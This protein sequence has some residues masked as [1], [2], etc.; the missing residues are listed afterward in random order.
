MYDQLERILSSKTFNRA[1]RL[2]DFFRYVVSILLAGRAEEIK[3]YNVAVEVFRRNDS[4]DPRIDPIVRVEAARLRSRLKAYLENEGKHDHLV[5]DLPKGGYVPII[6]RSN[7]HQT[8][9]HHSL[10]RQ[11][12]VGM[13]LEGS[14]RLIDGRLCVNAHLVDVNSDFNRSVG[15]DRQ[16]KDI[17]PARQEA[18]RRIV[19]DLRSQLPYENDNNVKNHDLTPSNGGGQNFTARGIETRFESD[20]KV[21]EESRRDFWLAV[22][23]YQDYGRALAILA[24]SYIRLGFQAGM[25]PDWV[26]PR[27]RV[28]AG[29]ALKLNCKLASAHTSL[30]INCLFYDW[31][32]V[33]AYHEFSKAL[34]INPSDLDGLNWYAH[35]VLLMKGPDSALPYIRRALDIRPGSVSTRLNL[36]IVLYFQQQYMES[37]KQIREVIRLDPQWPW[38]HWMAAVLYAQ[39]LLGKEA[40]CALETAMDLSLNNPGLLC[41]LAHI[42]GLFGMKVK[43]NR[44]VQEL[45][46]LSQRRYIPPVGLA[47]AY[48]GIGEVDRAIEC[49]ERAY[50]VRDIYL[51]YIKIMPVFAPLRTSSRFEDLIG[52]LGST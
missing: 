50:A 46:Q 6:R 41:W 25:T 12:T 31:N 29:E 13:S 3:E 38:G 27:A 20:P 44:L 16:M 28:A 36:S 10:A 4:F 1:K 34:E 40:F 37:L 32:R 35:L 11:I 7:F 18:T 14:V 30:G 42:C 43:A 24:K 51:V 19:I 8:E 23:E 45:I 22:E 49:L 33:G 52:R 47:L 26:M 17:K 15:R 9:P 21:L 5:I 39:Q 2:K 48:L